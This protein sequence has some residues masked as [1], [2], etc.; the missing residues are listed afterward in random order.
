MADLEVREDKTLLFLI[1]L[2]ALFLGLS[3][4]LAIIEAVLLTTYVL[5]KNY[6]ISLSKK[7]KYATCIL[8]IN[9]IIALYYKNYIGIL[10][11]TGIVFYLFVYDFYLSLGD[12]IKS[13]IEDIVLNTSIVTNIGY[14]IYFLITRQRVGVLSYFNPN[15][16][17]SYLTFIVILS[18]I[19]GKKYLHISLIGIIAIIATGSRFSLIA[20]L[21][22]LSA[23]ILFYFKNYFFV[24]ITTLMIYFAGVYKGILPFIRTDSISQY[25]KLRIDIWNMAI[26]YIRPNW[27]FG[28]G[29]GYF[30][31]ITN[32]VYAHTH[33]IL[34]EP[35][36]SYGLLGFT[37]LMILYLYKLQINKIKAIVLVLIFVHGLADYTILWYQTLVIYMIVF[38]LREE[39]L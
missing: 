24:F 28:H 34:L 22:A 20:V 18:L 17:G 35:I 16:Y 10:I 31:Y 33:S 32:S 3:Y 19:K 7:Q 1:Y 13:K 9:S 27:L 21:F 8:F 39:N 6:K 36:L 37:I 5:F 25:L 30:Y 23:Y 11:N 38:S 4:K 2:Q 15:Y 14:I 29:P 12:D 26:K